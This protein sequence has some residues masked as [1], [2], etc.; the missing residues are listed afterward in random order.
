MK[1]T[2][3]VLAY[4]LAVEVVIQA[5]TISYA[6]AALS[7]WV[8][9]DGGV[10]N[11]QL[12]DS[13]SAKYGGATGFA[14][15]GINGMM[16]IPLI[17]LALVVVSFF[18]KIPDGTRRAAVLFGMVVVQAVLG[19]SLHGVPLLAPLHALLAF[20]ILGMAYTAGSRTPKQTPAEVAV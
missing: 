18:A 4:A 1:T 6:M 8:E 15:H 10:L 11:K 20:G 12:L 7:R 19:V 17:A 2:Y 3:R 14:L 9:D 16:I 13:D 5:I